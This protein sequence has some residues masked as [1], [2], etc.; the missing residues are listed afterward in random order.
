MKETDRFL[1]EL[2][3]LKGKPTID[4]FIAQKQPLPKQ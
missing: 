1:S 2:G 3:W 4:H